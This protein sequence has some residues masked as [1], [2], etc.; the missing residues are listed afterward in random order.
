MN[1]RMNAKIVCALMIVASISSVDAQETSPS[2]TLTPLYTFLGEADGA[3]P[4]GV[5]LDPATN[6]YGTTYQG[7]INCAGYGCGVAFKI[8]TR[9]HETLLHTFTGGSDG[10]NPQAG[11]LRNSSGVLYGT[12]YFRGAGEKPLQREWSRS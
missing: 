8:D 12:T 1:A 7:G 5:V 4:V 3:S 11:L 9:G 6:L 2:W 10:G